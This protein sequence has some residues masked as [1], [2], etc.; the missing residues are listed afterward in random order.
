MD[1]LR[2]L[3]CEV[4]CLKKVIALLGLLVLMFSLVG[5]LDSD[6][7]GLDALTLRVDEDGRRYQKNEVG[8]YECYLY[9]RG[10][11]L[12]D[13]PYIGGDFHY[14][15]NV[16]RSN[17]EISFLYLVY[18]QDV[19]PQAKEALLTNSYYSRENRFSYAGFEFYE[20]L[21]CSSVHY[22]DGD[23]FP[24]RFSMLAYND[25]ARTI[26]VLY[27]NDYDNYGKSSGDN[28]YIRNDFGGFIEKHYGQYYDF[29]S[30]NTTEEA[31]G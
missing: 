30:S 21:L 3:E 17:I 11:F 19:Y 12:I 15:T 4:R 8:R 18:D 31:E 25:E 6:A 13:Y 29:S 16:N 10:S 22:Y 9:D 23:V 2:F 26:I 27:Y 1:S 20:N 28:E 24:D 5:C 14:L 7:H